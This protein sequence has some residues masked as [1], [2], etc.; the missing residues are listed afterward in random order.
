MNTIKTAALLLPLL[1]AVAWGTAFPAGC[2]TEASTSTAPGA[3]T[4]SSLAPASSETA[5]LVSIASAAEVWAASLAAV[6]ALGPTRVEVVETTQGRVLDDD[7][8]PE[9]AAFGP[10]TAEAE[11]LLD[12]P[13]DRARLRVH[14][15]DD[16]VKTTIVNG[17]ERTTVLDA[18]RGRGGALVSYG[19]YVSLEPPAGL[20]L[21]LWA[22]NAVAPT[23]GYADLLEDGSSGG[24][25]MMA[26]GTVEQLEDGGYRLSWQRS[27][28]GG[29]STLSL[30]LDA[31][32]LP[33]RIEIQGEGDLEGVRIEYSTVIDYRFEQQVSFTDADFALALQDDYWRTGDT[34]ELSLARPWSDRADWGQYWLGPQVADWVLVQAEHS[35]HHDNPDLGA[36][37]EPSAEFVFL[38]YDRPGAGSDNESIQVMVR[39]P[40]GESVG[41]SRT[42]AEQ[43]VAYGDWIR[44]ELTV[45]GQPAT[46]YSGALEGGADDRADTIYLFLPDA[47]IDIQVWAHVDPL[48]VLEAISRVE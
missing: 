14:E 29:T 33:I 47:M 15:S 31:D 9:N 5:P 44:R 41:H 32:Y 45:A 46:A 42:F 35:Q 37:A 39:P 26:K 30:L 38:L 27:S 40:R 21:P 13:R 11:E 43:R 17:R 3:A 48:A 12:A 34:Y 25:Q 18:S 7:V 1:I 28:E 23:H 36:G 2:G 24:A 22:G 20:P 6:K 10:Q 19:R 16:L 8:A 4:A